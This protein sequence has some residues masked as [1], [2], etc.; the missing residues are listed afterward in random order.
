MLLNA[1]SLVSVPDSCSPLMVTSCFS[2]LRQDPL[3][4]DFLRAI[5][6]TGVDQRSGSAPRLVDRHLPASAVRQPLQPKNDRVSLSRGKGRCDEEQDR[7]R[8]LS[9]CSHMSIL[10]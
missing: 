6:V 2:F 9:G 4:I 7:H 8:L 5:R 1:A 10:K 3:H